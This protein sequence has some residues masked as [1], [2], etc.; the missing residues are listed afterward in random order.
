MKENTKAWV[1]NPDNRSCVVALVKMIDGDGHT[2]FDRQGLPMVP[3]DVLD[4]Y[5]RA[6]IAHP[7]HPKSMI[8]GDEVSALLGGI[9]GL[10]LVQ[11]IG[12][13]LNIHSDRSGRG[14]ICRDLSRRILEKLDPPDYPPFFQVSGYARMAILD[15][16][17]LIVSRNASKDYLSY[18]IQHDRPQD[19][20]FGHHWRQA[21]AETRLVTLWQQATGRPSR[22]T[23]GIAEANQIASPELDI[24]PWLGPKPSFRFVGHDLNIPTDRMAL[25]VDYCMVVSLERDPDGQYTSVFADHRKGIL[26]VGLH[27]SWQKGERALVDRWRKEI[28]HEEQPL[29][30]TGGMTVRYLD[31]RT[32]NR[33]RGTFTVVVYQTEDTPPVTAQ[34]TRK[35]ARRMLASVYERRGQQ[36]AERLTAV[37]HQDASDDTIMCIRVMTT[38]LA[39]R[40]TSR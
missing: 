20:D 7:D 32:V 6:H 9:Q 1:E 38:E 39:E 31:L 2:I 36:D 33:H 4:E 16:C 34:V 35:E 12:R 5:E 11:G 13:V 24:P 28:G 21:D 37:W 8:E 27:P 26:E 23:K 40:L 17:Y 30:D 18:F 3:G 10:E 25:D 19:F 22:S 29:P 14:F 15:G